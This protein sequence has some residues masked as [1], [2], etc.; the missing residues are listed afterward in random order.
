MAPVEGKVTIMKTSKEDLLRYV[1]EVS[2]LA[3][4]AVSIGGGI[5]VNVHGY[6]RD[7]SDVDAFFHRSDRQKILRT[8]QCT[9]ASS[10]VLEELDPSHWI[11]VPEG[12]SPDERI[13]LMFA[14]GDPEESAIEM[15]VTKSYHGI[16]IPVFPVELLVA[17]KYLAGR[18]DPKDALDIYALWRR[19]TY[20]IE[21]IKKLLQQLQNFQ[22]ALRLFRPL[23]EI[24]GSL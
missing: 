1:L 11:L 8:I 9:D 6:R 10:I 3:G 20:D 7:T 2:R 15:A 13:D 18:E 4:S 19:G 12:N 21:S 22:F 14:S 24:G 23:Q 17:C 5:A 16:S